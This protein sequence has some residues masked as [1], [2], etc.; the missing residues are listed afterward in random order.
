M[1]LKGKVA[2]VT[3]GSSGIGRAIAIEYAKEGA[4]VVVADIREEPI[5]GGKKTIDIIKEQGQEAIFIKTDVSIWE[6]VNNLVT[7]TVKKYNKLDVY[8]NN[9]AYMGAGKPLVE[10]SEQEWDKAMNVNL[11]GA[12]FGCKRAIMQMMSQE[13]VNEA[14]GRIVNVTSQHGMVAALNNMSYGVSKSGL[15][16]LTRQ[17]ATDYAKDYI[18]C[19]AV[20]PGRILTGRPTTEES[21]AYSQSRTPYPRLGKPKDVATAAVFLA[22]DE[23][24]FI[25]GVNLMVDGGW[26][27]S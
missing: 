3:G 4:K 15:V 12:F 21:K 27:A 25:T 23:A 5:E 7:K 20:A 26:M 14:R 10:T 2:I 6:D 16:Y 19:N 13:V 8:V 24:K 9:A 18:I 1:R 11:K 22:S 17:V